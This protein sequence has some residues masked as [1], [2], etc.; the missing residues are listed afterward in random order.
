M[1]IRNAFCYHEMRQRNNDLGKSDS[2]DIIDS[3]EDED[4]ERPNDLKDA[5]EEVSYLA[6]SLLTSD[7]V[8]QEAILEAARFHGTHQ[9]QF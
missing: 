6:K 5:E 8:R 4:K 9:G 7:C 2:I 1:I 3:D